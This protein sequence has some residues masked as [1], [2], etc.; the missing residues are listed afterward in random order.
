MVNIS[1][2]EDVVLA[3]CRVLGATNGACGIP[4][5]GFAEFGLLCWHLVSDLP[6]V[7]CITWLLVREKIDV[8]IV[9]KD[10]VS[11]I[12]RNLQKDSDFDHSFYQ[13]IRGR[14]ADIEHLSDRIDRD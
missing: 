14:K 10:T 6:F 1:G 3:L 12:S 7:A 9:V 13:P 11:S 4:D 5:S 8:L 2:R